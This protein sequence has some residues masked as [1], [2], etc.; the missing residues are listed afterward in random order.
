MP[1]GKGIASSETAT[2]SPSKT[3]L[4]SPKRVHSHIVTENNI[5]YYEHL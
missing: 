2:P 5:P 1:N 4:A 3:V